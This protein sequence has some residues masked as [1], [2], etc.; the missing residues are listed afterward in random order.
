MINLVTF[1]MCML[2]T[3]SFMFIFK[4]LLGNVKFKFSSELKYLILIA[5][6]Y[7]ILKDISVKSVLLWI[8]YTVIQLSLFF[9]Y[10]DMYKERKFEFFLYYIVTFWIFQVSDIMTG[11]IISKWS[12]LGSILAESMVIAIITLQ[13]IVILISILLSSIIPY[14]KIINKK[15][16]MKENKLFWIY[17]NILILV[18]STLIHYYNKVFDTQSVIIISIFV[19]CLFLFISYFVFIA[20]NNLYV[21]KSIRNYVEMYNAVIEE[22]LENMKIYRHDHKNILLSIGGFLD[23]DDITELKKYFYENINENENINSKN[24]DG[25][26]NIKNRPVRG[27]IYAKI[28]KS[29]SSQ[30]NLNINV[31]DE[32]ENFY[33][34]DIDMCKILGI[35]IDNAIEACVE[36]KEKLLNI[37]IWNDDS[38]IY[39][40]VSNSFKEKPEIHKISEKGY[41]TKGSDRGL[42]FSIVQDLNE[43]KYSNMLINKRIEDSL[44]TVEV[45][46][47]K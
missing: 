26:V 18:Y 4:R 38:E 6:I 32:I 28:A 29:D 15:I 24:L 2:Y 21:E 14:I 47:Q 35:L 10:K 12:V 31:K 17:T 8:Y 23:N 30:I 11:I 1:I 45:I 22:T 34:K 3:Y 33:I 13:S 46:I 7:F 5:L 27:L 44:F 42:G 19:L 36:S 43:R 9:L 16:C 39:I 41:S 25:I 20:L 37:G 40:I